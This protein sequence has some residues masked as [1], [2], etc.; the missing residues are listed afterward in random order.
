MIERIRITMTKPS[1]VGLYSVMITIMFL[2]YAFIQQGEVKK[3]RFK[4]HAAEQSLAMDKQG[5]QLLLEVL[6][7]KNQKIAD[8][9]A[10]LNRTKAMLK[11]FTGGKPV[12]FT[13]YNALEWQTDDTPTITASNK[14]VHRGLIALSREQ[15][16]YYGHGGE[17]AWGDTVLAVMPMVVEDTMNKKLSNWADVF[18]H[19][20]PEAI[21]FGK[22]RGHIYHGTYSDLIDG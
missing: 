15:L 17:I 18:M 20:L 12:A 1:L 7:D 22:R 6:R 8:T 3:Q 21:A 13:A 4:T 19:G 16:R 10:T 9:Q 5:T 2:A 14:K 11:I